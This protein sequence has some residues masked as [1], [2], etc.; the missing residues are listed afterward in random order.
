METPIPVNRGV[1]LCWA[2]TPQQ[3]RLLPLRDS[4]LPERQFIPTDRGSVRAPVFTATGGRAPVLIPMKT[5]PFSWRALLC[6]LIPFV[7]P[8]TLVHAQATLHGIGDLPG[9]TS[10]SEVRDAT[11][12]AGVLHAV[13]TSNGEGGLDRAIYWTSIDGLSALPD[14]AGNIGHATPIIASA[15]TRDAAFIASRARKP[16]IAQRTAVRVA[17]AQLPAAAANLDIGAGFGNSAANTISADGTVLYG[18][19][20]ANSFRHE[21]GGAGTVIIPPIPGTFNSSAPAGRATSSDGSVVIG[22]MSNGSATTSAAWRYVHGTGVTPLPMLPGGTW[23]QA[24]ALS[25][26]GRLALLNSNST[27]Y[28]AGEFYLHHADTGH[29]RP[30]G[31]PGAGFSA[32]LGGMTA[33]GSVIGVNRYIRNNSGW[34]LF[35]TMLIAAGI[36]MAGWAEMGVLGLSHD[37]RLVWGRGSHNGNPEG[38]IAELPVGYLAT[39]GGAVAFYGVG[40]LPGGGVHSEVRDATKAGGLIHAVGASRTT[41]NQF[42][43]VLWT[44]TGGLVALPTLA[45]LNTANQ[46]FVTASAITPNAAYIAARSLTANTGNNRAA[47]RVTTA[48]MGILDPFGGT[49]PPG[50]GYANA[51]S[52]DGSIFYGVNGPQAVRFE[53]SGPTVIPIPRLLDSDTD[54]YPAFRGTSADGS[55][56]VGTSSTVG[57]ASFGVPSKAFRYVHGSGVSAIPFL[58]GGTCNSALHVSPSG[59]LTLVAGDASGE[60]EIQAYIHD[61][62]SNSITPIGSPRAGI[63]NTGNISDD[64]SL[65]AVTE[66][67]RNA[68]GWHSFRGLLTESGVNMADWHWVA[69]AGIS[70]DGTLAW[71][72]GTH[73]N[74]IREGF[75]AELPAGTFAAYTAPSI[76]GAWKIAGSDMTQDGAAVVVFLDDGYYFHVQ[77]TGPED[78]GEPSGFERGTYSWN[79][80]TGAFSATTEF[81]NN[82][83]VGLS[84]MSGASGISITVS[85]DSAQLV[86]PGE[87]TPYSLTRIVGAHPLVGAWG[88]VDGPSDSFVVVF[89]SSGAY[90]H[91]EQGLSD[92]GGFSGIEHGTWSWDPT[93]GVLTS[94]QSPAPYL[95]TNGEWG[96]S[97]PAGTPSLA[98]FSNCSVVVATDDIDSSIVHRIGPVTAPPPSI[99]IHPVSVSISSGASTVLSVTATGEALTYQWYAGLSGDVANPIA[100]ANGSTFDTGPL[101]GPANFWVRVTNPCGTADSNTA[102]ISI[103]TSAPVTAGTNQTVTAS[104]PGADVTLTFLNISEG[105]TVDV[106]TT[107]AGPPPPSGFQASTGTGDAVYYNIST[108]ATFTGLVDIVIEYNPANFTD[109]PGMRLFHYEDG[110]WVDITTWHDVANSKLYGQTDSFSPFALFEPSLTI[111]FTGPAPG[112]LTAVNTNITLAG[113]VPGHVAGTT[114][115]VAWTLGRPGFPT[116]EFLHTSSTGDLS[117]T[118]TLTQPGVYDVILSAVASGGKSATA[119]LVQPENLPGSIIVYDSTAGFVTGGGSIYSPAGAYVPMPDAEGLATFGFVSKYKKG[120]NVPDGNTNFQFHAGGLHFKSTSYDWLVIAGSK[121]QYKGTGTIN[122]QGSYKFMLSAL[123]SKTGDRFRIK[124]TT[125]AGGLVYDNQMGSAENAE[126]PASTQITSGSI[127]IHK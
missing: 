89:D 54:A 105:G 59:N 99:T 110:A 75:V 25:P 15:I 44:P 100:G 98:F 33:D 45:P 69:L 43:G 58:P 86:V 88:E 47:I 24:V 34:H 17:T 84:E 32:N 64:G 53:A 67:F 116:V 126:L 87:P 70:R 80:T 11:L 78:P 40:D 122:G 37:G 103:T 94:S 66:S 81:D 68:A 51:I 92:G 83:G 117:R 3:T 65:V 79:R 42:K 46:A 60:P 35:E 9:G 14:L 113:S 48:G 39:Y 21:I 82:G 109:I 13:G 52:D 73:A 123:D 31:A 19:A 125:Q 118:V 119:N 127:V 77:N 111:A 121:A 101:S 56:A 36:N 96:L 30:L 18:F 106:T 26:S 97:H 115:D 57:F 49:Y 112:I 93:T 41:N 23:N 6:A 91:A 16:A 85:G 1:L 27:A 61:A 107:V 50:L 2:P 120:A 102:A 29:L 5:R 7:A 12:V 10:L 62:I 8:A 22:S 71:G 4:V 28:P 20:G 72:T 95:D 55:V 38:F 114:Y 63:S 76:V 104:A 74:G 90:L 108:T 124:I